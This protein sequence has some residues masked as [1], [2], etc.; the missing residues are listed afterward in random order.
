MWTSL[1]EPQHLAAAEALGE[2]IVDLVDKRD[3]PRIREDRIGP[4]RFFSL[5]TLPIA[6]CQAADRRMGREVVFM[7]AKPAPSSAISTTLGMM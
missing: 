3:G 6:V 5:L 1:R 7:N 4:P 2:R